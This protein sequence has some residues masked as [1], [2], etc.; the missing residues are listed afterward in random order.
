MTTRLRLAVAPT[1]L[2]VLRLRAR[3][4]SALA[5]AVAGAGAL[6]GWSSL[7]AA[8]SQ[9]KSVRL[10]LKETPPKY[11]SLRVV[12]YTLPQESDYRARTVADALHAFAR[13]TTPLRR[14]RVWHSIERNDPLGTRLVVAQAPR[15]D[16]V[17]ASG[18][19][20]RGSRG[21]VCEAL[22]L[23]GRRR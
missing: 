21:R 9:A 11:R 5:L 8:L 14:V 7:T 10:A 6:I 16:V 17:V 23:T 2:A 1:L 19:L 4:F 18:R 22:A 12:Y 15:A 20:P 13:V 3:P